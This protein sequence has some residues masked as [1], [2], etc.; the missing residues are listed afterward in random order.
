MRPDY[1][2]K[3]F[4][5]KYGD[6]LKTWVIIIAMVSC[7][8]LGVSFFLWGVLSPTRALIYGIAF[9]L[10]Y[11]VFSRMMDR[12]SKYRQ[13]KRDEKVRSG[14]RAGK[15]KPGKGEKSS[16]QFNK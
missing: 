1:E 16:K 5:E 9:V 10:F 7:V 6:T 14:T 13:E 11:V 4:W 3:R 12:I 15:E 2:I 8:Y